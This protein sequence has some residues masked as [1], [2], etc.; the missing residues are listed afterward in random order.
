[1][2]TSFPAWILFAWAATAQAQ[3]YRCEAPNGVT[4]Y[5]N[6]AAADKDK[7][8]RQVS[9]PTMTTIPAPKLPAR[10]GANAAP[11]A[12]SASPAGFPKVDGATQKARDNDR[13]RILEDELAKEQ[14]RLA[15]IRKEYNGG[16]PERLGD[17]RN[18]QK[19]LDRVQRLK[20]DVE[21]AEGNVQS[22]K[23]EL[24]TIQ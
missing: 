11:A 23:R 8:C 20:E 19:Y 5:S 21:R 7:T 2:R 9:L 13:K 16:E 22:L 14:T 1:M 4:E 17:E 15:E 6:A 24:G 18:Y 12:A 3:I 10:A